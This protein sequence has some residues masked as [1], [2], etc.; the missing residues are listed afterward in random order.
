MANLKTEVEKLDIDKLATV[1]VD[2]SK[3]SNV[4]KNDV[5]KK[6]VYDK[7]VAKVD[8]ID[9]SGL[10][11]KTDYNTKITEIEDKIPDTSG[12]VKNTDYNTKITE[13]EDKIPD[14]SGLATKTALTTVENTIPSISGLVKKTD[15]NTKITDIENKLNNNNH[16]KYVATPEFN[17]LIANVFNARLAQANLIAKTDF[18]AKLSSLNRKITANKT[19][20][21]LNDNGLSYYRGK[22]YFDEGSGKQNYLVFLSMGKYFKLNS[23]AGAADYVLSW[24]SKG[25]SS[26]RIK[27]PTTNNSLTPELN[28]YGT[29][30]RVKVTKS[31]LKQSSHIL[32]HKNI[33]NIYIVYE[34]AASSSNVN[35]P[36][37]KSCLFGADTLTK[38]ADIEK[39]KYSGYG[40]GFDRRSSFSF[41]GGGYGQ[42]V[43]TFG[44]DVSSS[45]HTNNKRKVILVLER[46]PAQGLESTLTAEKMYSMNF[47]VTKKKLFK[48]TL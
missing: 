34:L 48:F 26:E 46:G 39:Y 17:T 37:I 24:Q 9:T 8:N 6:T 38:N 18:D 5:V 15:C 25:L 42:N 7:L 22:Q 31:C 3:L 43:L 19:K 35:D 28:H 10:V 2:L 27:P 44:A 47:T 13:I 20:D 1:P 12:L 21:F 32:T 14:I 4:V 23:V 36:T 41:T 29:K 30:A 45:V 40:I 11:K 33:V 16:D